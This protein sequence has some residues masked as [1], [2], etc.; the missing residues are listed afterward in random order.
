M[1]NPMLGRGWNFPPTLDERGTLAMTSDEQDVEQSIRIILGTA[2]GQR[3]MRPEF[4]CRVHEL[5]FA[6]NNT[7]TTG[8]AG[9]YVREA[10][11]RWE[12]RIEVQRV[13]VTPDAENQA[14]LLISVDYRLARTYN[15]RT[16]VYPFYVIPEERPSGAS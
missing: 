16:L 4:G 6:P 5:V 13:E 7:A 1:V 3:V 15:T 2:P 12:P 8:L 9:R 14:R 11:G 10:L